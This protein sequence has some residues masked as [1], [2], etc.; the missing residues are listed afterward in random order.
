MGHLIEIIFAASSAP[1]EFELHVMIPYDMFKTGT[2]V[3]LDRCIKEGLPCGATLVEAV[4]NGTTISKMFVRAVQI[5]DSLGSFENWVKI[6]TADLRFYQASSG[7][8]KIF[9]AEYSAEIPVN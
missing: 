4:I 6:D 8:L 1:S 7:S 9:F 5:N 3:D 2:Q